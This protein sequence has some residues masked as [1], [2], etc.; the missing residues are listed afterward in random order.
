MERRMNRFPENDIISLVGAPP[1]YELGESTGPDLR[2]A[3]LLDPE[4]IGILPLSY[5]TAAGDPGLRTAI[6]AAYGVDA[7]DVVVTSGGMHALFLLAF[8][9]CERRAEAAIAAPCF[10]PAR[11]ALTAIG[12]NIRSVELSFDK[13]YRLE[14][15]AFR[16]ALSPRTRLVSLAS[17]QNPSGVAISPA[18]LCETLRLMQ[19][20]CPEAY[21]L[22]DETYREAAYA[23]DP[24]AESAIALSPRVISVASLSKCDGAPGLRIGWA[25]T[26]DAALRRQLVVG[27]FNTIVSCPRVD[28]ALALRLLERRTV[29]LAERRVLLDAGL[30]R[31]DAWVR[32]NADYV[33]WVRPDAGALCCIRLRRASFDDDSVARFYRVAAA[34]GTRVAKGDW[35]GEKARVFR[36]GFGL[37]P[38]HELGDALAELTAALKETATAGRRS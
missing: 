14:P 23:D 34:K 3:D 35:F 10:P 6:G 12:A 29:T 22:I 30:R 17:P 36:L 4:A 21:L 38:V 8:I 7:D 11:N 5:G 24:V 32:A 26:R 27:K 28:E 15:E 2:L 16:N 37:L 33:E 31:I 25:I 19:E 1:H 20:T 13:G 9:L 18:A